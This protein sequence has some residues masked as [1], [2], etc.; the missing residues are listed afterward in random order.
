MSRKAL[1]ISSTICAAFCVCLFT[2]VSLADTLKLKDG[3]TIEGR[4]IQQGDR[5]WV[6]LADGSTK[7]IAKDQ[8]LTWTKSSAPGAAA[9]SPGATIPPAAAGAA[10]KASAAAP[11]APG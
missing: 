3:S 7:Y 9:G 5:Y 10:T 6:K 4:V 11:A 8:V 1:L 2:L